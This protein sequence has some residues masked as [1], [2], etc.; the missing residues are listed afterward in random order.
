M[1]LNSHINALLNTHQKSFLQQMAMNTE[2]HNWLVYSVQSIRDFGAQPSMVCLYHTSPLKVQGGGAERIKSQISR[3]QCFPQQGR[4]TH[5]LTSV[6]TLYTR[7]AKPQARQ[8]PS[9]M[10]MVGMKPPL[11]EELLD[12][13]TTARGKLSWLQWCDTWC[14]NHTSGQAPH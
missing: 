3:K 8:K 6:I 14:I 7:P 1:L 4:C 5:A 10:E 9:M 12:L 11:V 2:T 13:I